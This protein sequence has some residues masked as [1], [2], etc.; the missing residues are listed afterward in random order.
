MSHISQIQ[1]NFQAIEDRLLLRVSTLDSHIYQIWL[2]RRYVKVLWSALLR[3]LDKLHSPHHADKHTRAAI[4]SFRHEHIT[5]QADFS[6]DFNEQKAHYPFGDR[7]ILVSELEFKID[8]K[9]IQTLIMCPENEKGIELN[10]DEN[11]L[12]SLCKLLIDTVDATD[13]DLNLSLNPSIISFDETS[14]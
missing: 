2:T 9:G 11:I 8:E 3:G 6:S 7:P 5:E 14:H 1:L 10:L 13:W 12:H 4:I